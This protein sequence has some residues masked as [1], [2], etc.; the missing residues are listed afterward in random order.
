MRPAQPMVP[1]SE[2]AL[3]MAAAMMGQEGKLFEPPEP[4]APLPPQSEV[5]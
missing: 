1:V 2:T 3:A 4:P 5:E